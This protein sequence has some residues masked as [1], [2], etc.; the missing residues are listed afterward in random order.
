MENKRIII[1]GVI[2]LLT[3]I[4]ALEVFGVHPH[5]KIGRYQVHWDGYRRMKAMHS[6]GLPWFCSTEGADSG[7]DLRHHRMSTVYVLG[8]LSFWSRQTARPGKWEYKVAGPTS[9]QLREPGGLQQFL[10]DL[11]KDG[12]ILVNQNA[13]RTFNFERPIK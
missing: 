9:E 7:D 5:F 3:V 4:L 6:M 8:P 11:A 12:W 13:D 2:T 1:W 10:N